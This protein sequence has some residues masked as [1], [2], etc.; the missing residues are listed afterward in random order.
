MGSKFL[1]KQ[2]GGGEIF[3]NKAN[4]MPVTCCNCGHEDGEDPMKNRGFVNYLICRDKNRDNRIVI[5][6]PSYFMEKDEHMK[7]KGDPSGFVLKENF[8]FYE[9][10]V[11]CTSCHSSNVK[12]QEIE[13]PVNNM[14]RCNE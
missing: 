7:V 5:K 3:A 12:L 13:R 8:T 4:P 10:K 2:A 1:K 6:H 14:V 9:W 11:F